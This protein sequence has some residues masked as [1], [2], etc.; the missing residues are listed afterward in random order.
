M[1]CLRGYGESKVA[2]VLA[3]AVLLLY[4]CTHL[5]WCYHHWHYR[6]QQLL[7][8]NLQSYT[9]VPLPHDWAWSKYHSHEELVQLLTWINDTFDA[10][11][12]HLIGASVQNRQLLAVHLTGKQPSVPIWLNKPKVKVIG[13]IHGNEVANREVLL[14][15]V[16]YLAAHY[17]SSPRVTQLLDN[18]ELHI[19]PSMNP[20]GY[21]NNS[22]H[23]AN[24]FDLNRN[25]PFDNQPYGAS[26][27]SCTPS[28]SAMATA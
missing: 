16:H 18:V 28:L 15:L 12:V 25:F 11:H 26:L 27:A 2:A 9:E 24:D 3:S 14:R 21:E 10:A 23:N 17:G 1:H 13:N 7:S 5:Q 6:L 20:D 22:R 4:A 19:L 8:S